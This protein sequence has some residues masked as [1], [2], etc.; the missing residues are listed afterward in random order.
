M[1][2]LGWILRVFSLGSLFIGVPLKL[3]EFAVNKPPANLSEVSQSNQSSS[4]VILGSLSYLGS[5]VLLRAKRS[6]EPRPPSV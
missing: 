4:L 3:M 6:D 1:R 2:V 5:L